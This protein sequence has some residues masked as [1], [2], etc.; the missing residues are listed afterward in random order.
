[1]KQLD[2]AKEVRLAMGVSEESR[3]KMS[4]AKKGI[5]RG[6]M[7]EETKA[8]ISKANSSKN[9]SEETRERKSKAKSKK[10]KATNI[11][12]G[13]FIIFKNHHEAAEYFNVRDSSISRWIN[14]KRNPK[15][16]YKFENYTPATTERE[17]TE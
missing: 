15:I 9:M 16:P 1:M 7:S 4:E 3:R 13:T 11:N 2:K 12:D 8:K 10:V 14:G 5:K 17:G 6:P